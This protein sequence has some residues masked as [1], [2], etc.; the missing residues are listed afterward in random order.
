MTQEQR[1]HQISP[2]G[3]ALAVK[4]FVSRALRSVAIRGDGELELVTPFAL[5]RGRPS[6]ENRIGDL[7][8]RTREHV[9]SA[10]HSDKSRIPSV[11]GGDLIELESVTFTPF[12]GAGTPIHLSNLV[13]FSHD[14]VALRSTVLEEL[15]QLD[16]ILSP[17]LIHLD[18]LPRE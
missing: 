9:T 6:R 17:E 11:E 18:G 16:D 4:T 10:R 12:A 15:P 7:W 8:H 1:D 2:Y 3:E 13:V 5:I 14:V